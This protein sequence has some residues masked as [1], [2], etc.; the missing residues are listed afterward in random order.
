MHSVKRKQR[1]G[2]GDHT[3]PGYY[4]TAVP[5]IQAIPITVAAKPGILYPTVFAHYRPDLRDF[6]VEDDLADNN[7]PARSDAATRR[8]ASRTLSAWP[9]VVP[10]LF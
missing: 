2:Q 4:A 7:R 6:P 1:F 3:L 10:H 9:V 8:R 5:M